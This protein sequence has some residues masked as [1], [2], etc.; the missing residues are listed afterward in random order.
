[1]TVRRPRTLL[2]L[3][4]P[5]LAALPA[6]WMGYTR[7]DWLLLWSAMDPRSAPPG[8]AGVFARPLAALAWRAAVGLGGDQPRAM[9][10]L[11][12][13][14][15]LLL[16]LAAAWLA[17][18]VLPRAPRAPWIAAAVVGVHAALL[19]CRLWAAAC[20]GLLA[21]ALA[22]L[23]A[24]TA[25]AA[26]QP[27]RAGG[28]RAAL[29]AGAGVVLVALGGL[30]RADAWGA[31]L[32]IGAALLAR[33]AKARSADLTLAVDSTGHA[34][35]ALRVEGPRRRAAPAV[36]ATLALT[37]LAA[38]AAVLLTARSRLSGATEPAHPLAHPSMPELAHAGQLARLLLVPWGA[39]L[40]AAAA[41]VLGAIA[42]VALPG[43][44]W[45]QRSQPLRSAGHMLIAGVLG[46]SCLLPMQPAGRYVILPAVALGLAAAALDARVQAWPRAL[47]RAGFALALGA[48]LLLHVATPWLGSSAHELAAR[49]QAETA[50]YRMVRAEGTARGVAERLALIDAPPMGWRSSAGDA[51][52]VVSAALRHRVA[53]VLLDASQPLAAALPALRWTAGRWVWLRTPSADPLAP[54]ARDRLTT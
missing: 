38:T 9:H 49:A 16:A 48:W 8:A 13:L 45:R 12:F 43:L 46:A 40:N 35:G 23:G 20:N 4:L 41:A 34:R 27:A 21:A 29:Q 1:V 32:W 39:P 54:A 51:E 26:L 7:E 5:A 42:I 52:N 10:L 18:L 28:A 24:C 6:A 33:A 17:R 2:L 37:A 36:A 30:A 47:P 3:A 53:V 25:V 44:A 15:S 50:L 14:L 19:E 11:A 22:T 31:A